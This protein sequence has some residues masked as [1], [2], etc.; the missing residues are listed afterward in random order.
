MTLLSTSMSSY[1]K[2]LFR[3]TK[4]EKRMDFIN[5]H[6]RI[7]WVTRPS[8]NFCDVRVA[9]SLFFCIVF[10]VPLFVV[11]FVFKYSFNRLTIVLSALILTASSY[12]IDIFK[13]TLYY[14]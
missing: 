8:P 6:F 13:F 14:I 3:K 7:T 1:S 12:P 10:S 5:L 9:Q 2:T 4:S 11:C